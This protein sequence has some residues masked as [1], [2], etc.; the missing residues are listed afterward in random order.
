VTSNCIPPLT[1][2]GGSAT[3]TPSSLIYASGN[4]T[5]AVALGTH[6]YSFA[7]SGDAGTNG[8]GK[9]DFLCSVAGEATVGTC[10][11][12]GTTPT[13]LIVDALDFTVTSATGPLNIIPGVAPSGDGLPPAANQNSAAPGTA[14]I[15]VNGVLGFSGNV[16]IN[17]TTQNSYVNCVMYPPIVT[18]SSSGSGVTQTTILAVSTPASLPLAFTPTQLST[19]ATHTVLAF[20]PFGVL[21]FCVR[22]RRRLSKALW[23]LIAIVAVGAGMSGCG[24]NYTDFYTPIPTGPQT[25]SVIASSSSAGVSR[26]FVVPININ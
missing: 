3:F 24:S 6:N 20:L 26:T 7:Y 5:G 12:T 4:A 18:I 2:V 15:Q 8:D 23:T 16:N 14:A 19:S 13:S 9:G 22:R 10:A 1:L 21:A 25:V 11:T 17:C